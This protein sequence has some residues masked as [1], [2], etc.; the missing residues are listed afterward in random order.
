MA[1]RSKPIQNPNFD[2]ENHVIMT[3]AR[4]EAG[5]YPDDRQTACCDKKLVPND[6]VVTFPAIANGSLR[7]T[8]LVHRRCLASFLERVPLESALV[9]LRWE[10]VRQKHAAKSSNSVST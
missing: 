8:A 6:I 5:V 9:R 1:A 7:G 3:W 4:V 2:D 10:N